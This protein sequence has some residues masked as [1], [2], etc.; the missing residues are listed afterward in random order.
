[1]YRGHEITQTGGHSMLHHPKQE[2]VTNPL[3]MFSRPRQ[4]QVHANTSPDKFKRDFLEMDVYQAQAMLNDN[5]D[6]DDAI[7]QKDASPRDSQSPASV[8]DSK[9]PAASSTDPTNAHKDSS[10]N[11]ELDRPVL[12]RSQSSEL[13]VRP[14]NA[15]KA[16]PGEVPA[17]SERDHAAEAEAEQKNAGAL[18][19][20]ESAASTGSAG[21][22]NYVNQAR[23]SAVRESEK[24]EEDSKALQ[25]DIT[26]LPTNRNV[27][28]KPESNES[29][30]RFSFHHVFDKR[31]QEK[32]AA[33]AGDPSPQKQRRRTLSFT[34]TPDTSPVPHAESLKLNDETAE[35]DDS[36]IPAHPAVRP[37]SPEPETK[38]SNHNAPVPGLTSLI[39]PSSHTYGRCACCGKIK[40]PGYSSDLSPVLEN[41]NIRSNFSFEAQRTSQDGQR[42][43][44]PIIPM[45]VSDED[46]AG[47]IRTVQA[48]IE[49]FKSPEPSIASASASRTGP[50]TQHSN[51][52]SVSVDT[53]QSSGE[54]VHREMVTRPLKRH[55]MDEPKVVRFASLHGRRGSESDVPTDFSAS[56]ADEEIVQSVPFVQPLKQSPRPIL[57]PSEQEL[58]RQRLLQNKATATMSGAVPRAPHP[59]RQSAALDQPED[60]SHSEQSVSVQEA[61][62]QEVKRVPKQDIITVVPIKRQSQAGEL[63]SADETSP[64]EAK[65]L[66]AS[67]TEVMPASESTT[68]VSAP[69]DATSIAVPTPANSKSPPRKLQKQQSTEYPPSS[70]PTGQKASRRFSLPQAFRS[71]RSSTSPKDTIGV[72]YS[73]AKP[74]EAPDSDPA[75][76]PALPSQS[77]TARTSFASAVSEQSGGRSKDRSKDEKRNRS[78]SRETPLSRIVGGRRS[79]SASADRSSMVSLPTGGADMIRGVATG[80]ASAAGYSSALANGNTTGNAVNGAVG[81]GA[82][83]G[84]PKTVR[85]SPSFAKFIQQ[86]PASHA[87]A[88]EVP[89]VK[90]LFGMRRRSLQQGLPPTIAENGTAASSP[91]I[92]LNGNTVVKAGPGQK[93]QV[94]GGGGMT[95]SMSLPV[96]KIGEDEKDD[97]LGNG[98]NALQGFMKESGGHFT[99]SPVDIKTGGPDSP[100]DEM[101]GSAAS[102]GK[103]GGFVGGR[104]LQ[105]LLRGQ[106]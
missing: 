82:A 33:L 84:G 100:A 2:I 30:K 65:A 56:E 49:P 18:A 54:D 25:P 103:G 24:I 75:H 95:Q 72:P 35:P 3:S 105:M 70:F 78:S 71:K 38:S 83:A 99:T 102:T 22:S 1:M 94:N 34:K 27:D 91:K 96:L 31:G 29:R 87:T 41:E 10:A 81:D 76:K 36:V 61:Q 67:A 89:E 26:V 69:K 23:A 51:R 77:S 46:D 47:S 14:T 52:S 63:S 12:P 21:A 74:G 68:H 48:S 4:S 45:V 39:L 92:E 55:T 64:Q 13:T 15:Q 42:K 43:Y 37:I 8:E 11:E 19:T 80:D 5:S 40:K 58:Q 59:L 90:R 60:D 28:K 86:L 79:R 88:K 53:A 50:D 62:E 101:N 9:G 44:T 85:P 93:A 73:S 6:D 7:D 98:S 32:S 106:A 66:D 17:I 57:A 16:T 20:V 97:Y 104:K